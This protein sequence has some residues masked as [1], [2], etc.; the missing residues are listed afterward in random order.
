MCYFHPND[1]NLIISALFYSLSLT[2][3]EQA[4]LSSEHASALARCREGEQR[5]AGL[6]TESRVWLK[7]KEESVMRLEAV[8]R[9]HERLTAL[10]QR[11]E[12]ELEEL[13]VKHSQLKSSSRSLE[14][15]YKDTES[16]YSTLDI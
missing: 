11:Q 4:S 16:R 2:Q 3:V 8:R 5:Y 12:A 14:A 7:E 6:E 1:C 15:Q 13:L 10:Q 9:D